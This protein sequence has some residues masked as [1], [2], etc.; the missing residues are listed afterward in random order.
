MSRAGASVL[1]LTILIANSAAGIRRLPHPAEFFEVNGHT[2]YLMKAD[3]P[4]DG[5]PWVWYAPTLN[6][7]P[8]GSQKFYFEQFLTNGIAVAGCD[9]G[10]VR[11]APGSSAKFNAFYDAMVA[12]G[13]SKK[14][15]LMGQ[16]RGGLMMLCWAFRNPDKV[17][18]FVGIYPVCNLA[19]WPM[20]HSKG[21]VL[22]DYGLS[23]ED[24]LKRID[25]F[26]P[27]EN[28]AVLARKRV[29]MFIIHGDSDK[30]VPY[31]ENSQLIKDAYEKA[32]G[33]I[34]VKIVPGKG[35]AE[36]PE[37]FTD[38]DLIKFVREQSEKAKRR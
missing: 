3:A 25:T 30:V 6:N 20:R 35:H 1:I 8:H 2:A 36:I 12:K 24:L 13:Y 38:Q 9:L 4:A 11:G 37:F 18:A 33:D 19:S 23:E 21:S 7:Y 26:N 16:S 22:A 32:G 17:G 14:P 15:I 31:N 29:P 27:P 5:G 28:V 10:E 34:T